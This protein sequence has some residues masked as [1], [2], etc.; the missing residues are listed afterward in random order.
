MWDFIV[1][2]WIDFAMAGLVV[3]IGD[4]IRKHKATQLGVQAL[5]RANIISLYNK[6]IEKQELPIY[7]RENLEHL[8]NQYKNLK[9]NGVIDG[10]YEK[11]MELPTPNERR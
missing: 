2:Y 3:V 11:L 4:I 7:E 1:K 5:L 9:G 6:Y 10:L 8:H